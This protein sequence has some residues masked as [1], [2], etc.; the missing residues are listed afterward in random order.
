MADIDMSTNCSATLGSWT[1]IGATGTNFAGTFDGN[2]HTLSN[3]YYNSNAYH[4]VGLFSLIQENTIVQNIILKEVYI[5]NTKSRMDE[6]DTGAIA[7]NSSGK[8]NNVGVESGSI[9][10]NNVASGNTWSILSRVGGI[11]G[12]LLNNGEINCC[13]N[14]A[15]IYS[16]VKLH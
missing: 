14:K 16:Y 9:I 3:L 2:Y 4:N 10:G 13:Y 6:I 7:G 11:V 1:P 5:N 12:F 8:I 15:K